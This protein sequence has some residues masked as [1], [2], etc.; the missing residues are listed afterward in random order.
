MTLRD[1]QL[2]IAVSAAVLLKE[3]AIWEDIPGYEGYYQISNSCIVR[4]LDRHVNVKN[5]FKRLLKGR[6]MRPYVGRDGYVYYL[7]TVNKISKHIAA[8]RLLATTFINNPENKPEVNH[9]DTVRTNNLIDNLEWV[10]SKENIQHS[11]KAG[12]NRHCLPGI[13]NPAAKLSEKQ[14]LEIRKANGSHSVIASAYNVSRRTVGFIKNKQR[15][16]HL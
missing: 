11:I 2:S 12:T 6:I 8:H 7:L 5:G 13:N 16:A 4:S 15:W 1:Y 10:T 3:E 14:V 9:K